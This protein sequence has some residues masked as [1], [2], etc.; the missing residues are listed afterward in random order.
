[1]TRRARTGHPALFDL[2]DV[3]PSD[4][5][6]SRVA[7]DARP[8]GVSE[9]HRQLVLHHLERAGRMGLTDFDLEARTGIKQ[10]SIGKRRGDLTRRGLVEPKIGGDGLPVWRPAPSGCPAQVWVLAQYAH[11]EAS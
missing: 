6:T 4:P 9:R 1:V 8:F 11:A 10:T 5:E 3:R 7:A 2:G